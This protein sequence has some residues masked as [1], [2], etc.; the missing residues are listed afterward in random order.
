MSPTRSPHSV[1]APA[2]MPTLDAV[3]RTI[4]AVLIQDARTPNNSLAAQAGIA[5]STCLGRVGRCG[6]RG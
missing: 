5:P 1:G 4:L 3:D 6:R 2:A